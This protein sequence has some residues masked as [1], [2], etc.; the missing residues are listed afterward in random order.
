MRACIGPKCVGRPEVCQRRPAQPRV[1]HVYSRGVWPMQL[2]VAHA[3]V[4]K[5]GLLEDTAVRVLH[6]RAQRSP[7]SVGLLCTD[8]RYSQSDRAGACVRAS[9]CACECACVRATT[10][11]AWWCVSCVSPEK[12]P[13]GSRTGRASEKGHMLC[14]LV[15]LVCVLLILFVCLFVFFLSGLL[16]FR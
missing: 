9:V 1:V 12:Q 7:L 4:H 10:Q 11:F 16:G 8:G 15:C 2:C 14:C 6:A 13:A 3:V 5:R